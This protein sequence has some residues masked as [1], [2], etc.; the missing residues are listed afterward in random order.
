MVRADVYFNRGNR[1]SHVFIFMETVHCEAVEEK[2]YVCGVS[3]CVVYGIRVWVH[4]IY[5][6]AWAA[7]AL[8]SGIV[9]VLPVGNT[10]IR[11]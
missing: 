1:R 11:G 4:G 10:G 2:P 9:L 5:Q 3:H 7:D 8:L 6:D